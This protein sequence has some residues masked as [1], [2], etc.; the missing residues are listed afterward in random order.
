MATSKKIIAS[1]ANPLVKGLLK[2]SKSSHERRK[3]GRTVL[4]GAH[5]IKA[6]HEARHRIDTLV[7]SES[8][9]KRPELLDLYERVNA[10]HR[11]QLSDSLFG[12]IATVTTP[13][14]IM[15]L[16]DTP[17][18]KTAAR[19]DRDAVL[20]ETIQDP[21]NL[22]SILRSAAA[23]GVRQVL[24][25][26]GSVFAWSPKVLRAGM[27]AHFHLEIFEDVDLA[28]F[29]REFGGACVAT[30][31]Y[32]ALDLFELELADPTA[33]V[34]GNEG[35]GLSAELSEAAHRRVRIP[36][37]GAAESL[38]IAAAAAICLFEQV[39]RRSK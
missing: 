29:A 36:M 17:V 1:R 16:V 23:A 12:E 2:L 24:L 32:A 34:F 31:A 35:A 25:S 4:D 13:S 37:P 21:G 15:A 11:V 27:G 3:Q 33:W 22:G 38:N 20:L 9:A 18:P 6:F 39:R 8:G 7:L 5:L 19:G 14:G 28:A 26:K 10:E 30:D